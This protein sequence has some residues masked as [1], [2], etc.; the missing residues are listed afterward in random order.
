MNNNFAT[1]IE[2]MYSSVL[3]AVNNYALSN[4]FTIKIK[5]RK[6]LTLHLA[7]AKAGTYYNKCNISEDK[8]KK[9]QIS[10]FACQWRQLTL[11]QLPY[12]PKYLASSHQVRMSLLTPADANIA[13]I[14]LENHA[15]AHDIQKA[16]SDKVTDMRKIRISNI[17][18]LKY[19]AS[20]EDD[21]SNYAATTLIKNIEAK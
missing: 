14:I 10:S 11:P 4:N 13:K 18:N 3:Q 21:E 8:R 12:Y 9:Q 15:K 19:S 2:Q 1:P 20:R 16:I 6:F 17:N 7:C 5:N